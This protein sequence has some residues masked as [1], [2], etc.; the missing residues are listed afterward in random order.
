MKT[1]HSEN[2][3]R[4]FKKYDKECPRCQE[5]ANGAEPREAWFTPQPQRHYISSCNHNN[6]NPGGYCNTCG[7]G[8]D[9]S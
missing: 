1:L 9:F 8:R 6:L 2:C 7:A 3:K 5:L 4:V